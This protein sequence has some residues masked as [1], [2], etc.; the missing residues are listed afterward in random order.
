MRKTGLFIAFC[1]AALLLTS[2]TAFGQK[3]TKDYDKTYDFSKDHSYYWIK[4]DV[5]N[6]LWQKRIQTEID[7]QLAAKGWTKGDGTGDLA[8]SAL[9]TTAT[10]T[11]LNTFYSGM[12]GWGWYGGGMATA[13]TTQEQYTT[14]TLILDMF[15]ASNHQLVWRGV[16]T[17]TMSDKPEKNEKKVEKAIDKLLED[18]P[19]KPKK[20]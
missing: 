15:D 10:K 12:G 5:A 9:G 3:V 14:G 18:F 20:D 8:L 16:A 7:E 1:I 6:P 2:V 11:N 17:D 19:P 13:T 4:I